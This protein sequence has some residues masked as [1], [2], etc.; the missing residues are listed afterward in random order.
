MLFGDGRLTCGHGFSDL[1]HWF[2]FDG[3]IGAGGDGRADGAEGGG[4]EAGGCCSEC[5]HC[6]VED[7]DDQERRDCGTISIC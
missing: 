5:R 6:W 3:G 1:A 2:D 7:V 4:D